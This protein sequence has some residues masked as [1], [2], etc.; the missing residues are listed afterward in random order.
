MD[1]SWT[2]VFY[3][4]LI[5]SKLVTCSLIFMRSKLRKKHSRKH[6]TPLFQCHARCQHR[7]CPLRV[8]IAM[9]QPISVGHN[10]V[11][12]VCLTGNRQHDDAS[13]VTGRPLKGN[14]RRQMG[15]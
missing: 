10:V 2:D 5:A 4:K 8:R 14:K 9:A 12:R 6:N 3:E 7:T 11:F 1:S 15:E 13:I